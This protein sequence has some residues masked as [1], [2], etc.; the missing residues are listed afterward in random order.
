MKGGC[1]AKKA[2]LGLTIQAE[3]EAGLE[4]A[5]A[6]VTSKYIELWLDCPH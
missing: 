6:S 2:V 4:Y 3:R 5:N 1:F